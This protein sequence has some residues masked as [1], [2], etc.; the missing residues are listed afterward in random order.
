MR[1]WTLETAVEQVPGGAILT[2]TGRVGRVTA[3][4]FAAALSAARRNAST[5]IVDLKGVDYLSGLGLLALRE[6][7]D[8]ADAVI[9]CGVGEALRNTLELA[10]LLE[11]VRVEENRGAA[12]ER[13]RGIAP[14]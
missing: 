14:D 4:R 3:S 10:G 12:L 6:A 8:S 1:T 2:A 11:R 7:A 13:L 9:L 5:V